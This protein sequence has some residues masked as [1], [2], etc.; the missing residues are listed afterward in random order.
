M[1][2]LILY[3]SR[4]GSTKQYA[5]WLHEEFSNSDLVNLDKFDEKTIKE[6][7]LVVLGSPTYGKRIIAGD[8]L[9]K[10]WEIL[11]EKKVYLMV[12][13]AIPQK[14]AASKSAYKKIPE[15]IRNSLVGYSKLPGKMGEMNRF[16]KIIM[17]MMLGVDPKKIVVQES[18]KKKDLQPIIDFLRKVNVDN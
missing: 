1:K 16:G 15:E 9:K 5:Q 17:R 4:S 18:V 14:E 8:F 6:Y 10:N 12:V 13:G 3:K 2:T 7:D 11:E